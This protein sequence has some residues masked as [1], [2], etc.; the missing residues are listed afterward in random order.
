MSERI[1]WEPILPLIGVGIGFLLSQLTDL[2]KNKRR[3]AL[4]GRG[5]INKLSIIQKTLSDA[6]KKKEPR[7]S[8]EQ[9]PLIT[10]TYD[11]VKIELASFLKPDSLAIVQRT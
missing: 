4:I 7:I 1:P 9:I 3:K 8:D 11:S 2:I 5:L 6:L 10:E